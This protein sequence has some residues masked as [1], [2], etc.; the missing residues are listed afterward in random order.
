MACNSQEI[1]IIAE[2]VSAKLRY[3]AHNEVFSLESGTYFQCDLT[4]KI[5]LKVTE[6][7]GPIKSPKL[8]V[9]KRA[10]SGKPIPERSSSETT[11]LKPDIDLPPAGLQGCPPEFSA[12]DLCLEVLLLLAEQFPEV[13][14][15]GGNPTSLTLR[16]FPYSQNEV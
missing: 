14:R 15:S 4:E 16:L 1:K 7:C 6:S 13:I 11:G 8:S 9:L 10:L 12:P 3:R 5:H 2:R